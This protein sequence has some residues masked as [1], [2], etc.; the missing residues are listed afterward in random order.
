MVADRL[1]RREAALLCS[2]SESDLAPSPDG[3]EAYK[4]SRAGDTDGDPPTLKLVGGVI[5]R[6]AG[7]SGELSA[8]MYFRL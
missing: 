8:T 3:G 4:K 5:E 1:G 2:W 7:N 6:G